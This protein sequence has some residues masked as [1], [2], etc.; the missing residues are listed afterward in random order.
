MIYQTILPEFAHYLFLY[1]M[2]AG[3]FAL[4]FIHNLYNYQP[5]NYKKGL[6]ILFALLS[7]F[8]ITLFIRVTAPYKFSADFLFGISVLLI[9]S[10][11]VSGAYSLSAYLREKGDIKPALKINILHFVDDYVM[12]FDKD[13]SLI[14]STCPK[15]I[16]SK[17]SMLKEELR[18]ELEH[19]GE[20]FHFSFSPVLDNDCPTGSVGIISNITVEK[21]LLAELAIKGENLDYINQELDKQVNVD[22]ALLIAKQQRQVSMEIQE[23]IEQK[24]SELI[25]VIAQIEEEKFITKQ[26]R[27]IE[28]LA[29][30]LRFILQDIRKIVYGR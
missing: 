13:G 1:G 25:K 21:K 29:E 10:A 12:V 11:A 22:D 17:I 7:A 6:M 3:L 28:E 24:I 27:N 23:N 14:F 4:V 19:E 16:E 9:V 30:K 26:I 5:F 2:L 20:Y 15:E 18:S 8:F